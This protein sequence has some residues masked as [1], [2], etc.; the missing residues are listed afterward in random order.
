MRQGGRVNPDRSTARSTKRCPVPRKGTQGRWHPLVIRGQRSCSFAGDTAIAE[1][2]LLLLLS[3]CVG[4]ARPTTQEV[5]AHSYTFTGGVFR[6]VAGT[7][8][9]VPIDKGRVETR[10]VANSVVVSYVLSL[11]VFTLVLGGACAVFLLVPALAWGISPLLPC[12]FATTAF[13]I[14]RVQTRSRFD[15]V[16]ARCLTQARPRV[17]REA[18]RGDARPEGEARESGAPA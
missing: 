14:T 17:L 10:V 1:R 8:L 18:T 5:A 7:N 3:S 13:G 6:L 4:A 15:R 12:V 11:R 9:L 2:E 16:V